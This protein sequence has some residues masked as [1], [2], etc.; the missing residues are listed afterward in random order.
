[1]CTVNFLFNVSRRVGR[2][3]QWR[4]VCWS[5]LEASV[6]LLRPAS[7]SQWPVQK[8][9]SGCFQ[10]FSGGPPWLFW[11]P[12]PLFLLRQ[13]CFVTARMQPRWCQ[14]WRLR[15]I[16]SSGPPYPRA[17]TWSCGAGSPQGGRT[18]HRK[19]RVRDLIQNQDFGR[20]KIW[21]LAR[22]SRLGGVRCR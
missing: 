16:S 17:W 3:P 9:N 2:T 13:N 22:K 8:M 10:R 20:R 4:R 21:F 19:S 18:S 6:W 11:Q 5:R 14:G 1:M 7:G 12:L 15:L